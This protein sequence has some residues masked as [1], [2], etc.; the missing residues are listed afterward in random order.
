MK[1]ADAPCVSLRPKSKIFDRDSRERTVVTTNP[2]GKAV[3]EITAKNTR[4]KEGRAGGRASE[5]PTRLTATPK[6]GAADATVSINQAIGKRGIFTAAWPPGGVPSDKVESRSGQLIRSRSSRVSHGNGS[7]PLFRVPLF[8]LASRRKRFAS[9]FSERFAFSNG[10]SS[11]LR[12]SIPTNCAGAIGA[13]G[14]AC[15]QRGTWDHRRSRASGRLRE[16]SQ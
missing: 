1:R 4:R 5:P 7:R 13:P 8:A 9:L 2:D 3:L 11:S 10:F 6:S 14:L 15:R 12:P 16:M